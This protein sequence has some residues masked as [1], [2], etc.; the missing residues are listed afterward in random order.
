M[1]ALDH[2]VADG[3]IPVVNP[4]TGQVDYRIYSPSAAEITRLC[5][6]LRAGQPAWR[7]LG[8]R[9]RI[10]VMLA[11]ADAIDASSTEI[12]EA[13]AADTGR[14]RA[15]HEVPHLVADS[16]RG[17]CAQAPEVIEQAALSGVSSTSPSITYQMEFDP[18]PLLGVMSPWNHPFLLS[19]LDAIPALLAGCAVII[20]PSEIT[21]RFIEPVAATIES[22][23]ELH[24]VL[25][26][27]A[28]AASVGQ[29][30][31]TNVDALC[32]TGS[33]ATGRAIAVTCAQ[34]FIP[35]F[36]ELGG[37]DP[38]IVTSSVDIAQ[39]AASVVKGSV[40]NTGQLCFSTE[41]VYVDRAIHDQF[42]DE[43]VAQAEKLDL[44]FPDIGHG[45]LG[46]FISGRQAEIVDSQ[47]A[48]ALSRGARLRCG[49]PSE[50]HDGGRYMRATVLTDVNH[51][52]AIMREETFGP[53]IPVMAFDDTAQALQLANDTIFGLSG[54]VIAG[55]PEEAAQIASR[56][57]AGAIS[58]QDTSLNV[59]I[60]R[61]AEKVAFGQSGLGGSRMGPAALIRF[62]RKKAL[63]ERH[64]PVLSMDA[65]SED[66]FAPS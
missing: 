38:V 24:K 43:L 35:A 36:L 57:N 60:M 17:W 51:D 8:L 22:V 21:P 23:A 56:L 5:S 48:D 45:H 29:A 25:R 20:K 53:V 11:W 14:R 12:A 64:G 1:N 52:M 37:N 41:R 50:S 13:E 26:F 59:N 54:A 63:I 33:V 39:A 10:E 19:T 65:L 15:S 62:L 34:R 66:G 2:E 27:V 40:Q 55:T 61:D 28:G 9:G 16:V 46:P 58:L 42:V 3:H 31:I 30:I 7:D 4:R 47:L 6:E 49:G 44:N 18:Y 32:F